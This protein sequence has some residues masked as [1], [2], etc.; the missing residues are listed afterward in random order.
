M[1]NEC[2]YKTMFLSGV[3]LP[4][5]EILYTIYRGVFVVY[6]I[7]SFGFTLDC[8]VFNLCNSGQRFGGKPVMA[9]GKPTSIRQNSS[10]TFFVT[11]SLRRQ[12]FRFHATLWQLSQRRSSFGFTLYIV[13]CAFREIFGITSVDP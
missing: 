12:F 7:Y 4:F 8:K 1:L 5:R 3:I 10:P 9:P 2:S 6:F 13:V 11:S